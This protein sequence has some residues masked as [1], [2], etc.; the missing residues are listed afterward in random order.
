MIQLDIY[1]F[2]RPL[3][4]RPVSSQEG[5]IPISVMGK[6]VFVKEDKVEAVVAD[7][8][9]KDE[10]SKAVEQVKK[11]RKLT[12]NLEVFIHSFIVDRPDLP[13]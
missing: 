10:I 9:G 11:V 2:R 1:L 6:P 3:T 7:A 5:A 13:V 12:F 4:F 8:E